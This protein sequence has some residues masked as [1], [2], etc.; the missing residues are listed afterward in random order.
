MKKVKHVNSAT[1]EETEVEF[2]QYQFDLAHTLKDSL[3][4]KL[5]LSEYVTNVMSN[6]AGDALVFGVIKNRKPGE[7]VHKYKITVEKI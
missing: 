6:D 3:D 1:F 4:K 2:E 5:N 7:V